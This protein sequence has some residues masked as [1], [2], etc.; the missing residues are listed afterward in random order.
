MFLYILVFIIA[1]LYHLLAQGKARHSNILLASFLAYLALFVGFGDMIGGYDRYIYGDAFDAIANTLRGK[2]SLE[3]F[4]YLVSGSEY[5]YFLW[6]V[7]V[8]CFTPN[9]YVFILITTLLVYA[10]Y[11]RAFRKYMET[12]PLPCIL[13]VGFL[14]F[15]TM[16]YLRAVIAVGILWQGVKY[17]WERKLLKFSL[18]L[19]LAYSFHS[20]AMI[21]LPL[22]FM[23]QKKLSKSLVLKMLAVSLLIGLTPIPVS[24]LSSAGEASGKIES[25]L[26]YASQDQGFRIEYVFEVLFII[27]FIFKNYKYIKLDPKTL[28]FLNMSFIFCC[29]LLVFMRFGQGGRFTWPFFLGIFYILPTI[30]SNTKGM[31]YKK[32]ILIF[33]SFA[34]FY[35]L[36]VAWAP[37]NIPYKTFLVDGEPSGDGS[38]YQFFEYDKMYSKD[39][40]YRPA[41][42]PI[43]FK[44]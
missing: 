25:G 6:E 2:G 39:K 37:L 35:R 28:T 14:F 33:V 16:T 44:K 36:V 30:A 22:Y 7:I 9:R 4:L 17:I 19:L 5:G 29:V 12:Y 3:D 18:I 1:F 23:P 32:P 27:W 31:K 42:E 24:L 13:F 41:F 40:F 38:I 21:V 20:S 10:L 11:Y 8:G 15:F 43:L 26:S 34:L